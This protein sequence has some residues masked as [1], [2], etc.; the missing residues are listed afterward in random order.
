MLAP[1][2]RR[3]PRLASCR[4][5]AG[6][7]PDDGGDLLEGDGEQ[8]VQHE[9]QAL[10]RAEGVEHHEERKAHRVREDGLV[11][12]VGNGRRP[13][14]RLEHAVAQRVLPPGRPGAQHVQAD[15]RGDRGQPPREVLHLAGV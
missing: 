6:E 4:A 15:A 2:T 1:R 14:A 5:A 12:G 3:R 11:L 8:V 13:D 9:G 10:R 7:R